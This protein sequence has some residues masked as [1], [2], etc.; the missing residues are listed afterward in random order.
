[1]NIHFIKGGVF[2][3]TETNSRSGVKMEKFKDKI[4]EHHYLI[5]YLKMAA[6]LLVQKIPR[7]Y[8]LCDRKSSILKEM[9]KK[10]CF[11]TPEFWF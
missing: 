10:I 7:M 6:L 4:D 8:F 5:L 9:Y 11:F 3:G 2:A 1:M